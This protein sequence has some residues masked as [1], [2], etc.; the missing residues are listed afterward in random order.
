MI[1]IQREAWA[2]CVQEILPLWRGAHAEETV[3]RTK[4]AQLQVNPNLDSVQM[5]ANEN[6]VVLFTIR[7]EDI[8]IGY[9]VVI[10]APDFSCSHLL[11]CNVMLHYLMPKY[12]G[13]GYGEK[14]FTFIETYAHCIN[15]DGVMAG[16]KAHLPHGGMFEHIGYH[17][18]GTTYVKWINNV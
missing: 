13:Q 6:M 3:D 4:D 9:A 14:L 17:A 1:T 15:A 5:L 11:I 7:D 10:V 2:A 12:R 16:N 18:Y 8:L